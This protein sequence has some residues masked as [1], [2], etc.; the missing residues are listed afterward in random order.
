MYGLVNKAAQDFVIEGHGEEVWQIIKTKAGVDEVAF[1]SMQPYP[2][3]ITYNIVGA[4]SEH[5]GANPDDILEAFGQY[6]IKFTMEEGYSHVLDL[7]GRTFPEF[8]NNLNNMHAHIA[9]SFTELK[10][11]TFFCET[12][13]AHTF[14]FEY[15]TERPGLVRFV[16]GLLLGLGERFKITVGVEYIGTIDG[17]ENSHEYRVTYN[18]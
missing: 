14:K 5:L 8:L 17:N 18:S 10:P 2:D 9:Q 11:P 12:I 13:D 7:A 6:W 4:A 1:V 3:E 16:K 15:H